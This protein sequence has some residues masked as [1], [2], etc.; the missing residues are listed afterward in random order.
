MAALADAGLFPDHPY[1]IKYSKNDFLRILEMG[2]V[3][4]Q[5]VIID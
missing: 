2:D 1:N 5:N 3:N 4:V